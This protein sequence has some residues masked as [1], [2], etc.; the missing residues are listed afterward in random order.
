M[1]KPLRSV[2]DLLASIFPKSDAR[3]QQ[4]SPKYTDPPAQSYAQQMA[5][6]QQ[7]IVINIYG[8]G[9]T[10]EQ[11]LA[12]Y[13]QAQQAQQQA[14]WRAQQQDHERQSQAQARAHE[15]YLARYQQEV[16]AQQR[17]YQDYLARYELYG[18]AHKA[19]ALAGLPLPVA[20]VQGVSSERAAQ[21]TQGYRK[22]IVEASW[23]E[24]NKPE[25]GRRP[26]HSGYQDQY[27]RWWC[28]DCGIE[29]PPPAIPPPGTKLCNGQWA[30]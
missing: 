17:E 7:P 8:N 29:T 10:Y 20:P 14:Q 4:A 3:K 5:A 25:P 12:A 9:L 22:I 23:Q 19:A 30:S 18:Q 21:E 16:D 6:F 28:R 26:W 11:Q 15:E 27:G 24:M 2:D 13:Q 1:D